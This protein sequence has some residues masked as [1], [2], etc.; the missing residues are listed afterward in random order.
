MGYVAV[1]LD[2][3]IVVSSEQELKGV[4]SNSSIESVGD[5]ES[6]SIDILTDSGETF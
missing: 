2:I 6:G 1:S 3:T 5:R 4:A